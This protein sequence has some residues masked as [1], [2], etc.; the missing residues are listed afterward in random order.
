MIMI[1]IMKA[2]NKGKR[3]I[4]ENVVLW[5]KDLWGITRII[6]IM[7]MIIIMKAANKGKRIIR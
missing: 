7:N 4:R 1:I 3:I 2:E 6:V 5:D